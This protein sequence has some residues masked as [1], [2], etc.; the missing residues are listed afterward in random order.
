MPR[1]RSTDGLR[2]FLLTVKDRPKHEHHRRGNGHQHERVRL[3]AHDPLHTSGSSAP[4]GGPRSSPIRP[5]SAQRLAGGRPVSHSLT[6]VELQP[7]AHSDIAM[8]P[9]IF[10]RNAN[11][12]RD[13]ERSECTRPSQSQ[14][15]ST[16][17]AQE[18]ER[19]RK[20]QL[21][22]GRNRFFCDGKLVTSRQNG[23]FVFTIFAISTSLTLF[24]IFEGP[25]LCKEVSVAVPIVVALLSIFNIINLFRV[26]FMD[27]GIIPRATNLEVIED[28]RLQRLDRA[29]AEDAA[30]GMQRTKQVMLGGQMI[31]LKYCT[32]CRIFRPPRAS[33]CSV[34]DNCVANFDHHCPWVGNCVG[35]RNYRYFYFFVISLVLLMFIF[36]ACCITHIVM[37]IKRHRGQFIDAVR[38]TPISLVLCCILVPAAFTVIGLSGFHTY[39]IARNTT[40]NEDMK[41]TFKRRPNVK[42]P[43]NTGSICKNFCVRLCTADAPS[44]LDATGWADE[45]P[46]LQLDVTKSPANGRS[47]AAPGRGRDNG[48]FTVTIDN[49]TGLRV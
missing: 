13:V 33:H 32:T 38:V 45:H 36:A 26:S 24:F 17:S 40:T 19:K 23:V 42:N 14:Q 18:P 47:P 1:T 37:E 44:M 28:E 12:V 27:P 7:I 20:W 29:T 30:R 16:S 46:G 25:F 11:A 48:I 4:D 9:P 31:K 21:H 35:L 34:C 5:S 10:N 39:L 8:G 41:G 43:F 15:P 6:D 22:Q 49:E 3:C 2:P